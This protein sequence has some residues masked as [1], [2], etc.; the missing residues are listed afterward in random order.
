MQPPRRRSDIW[1]AQYRYVITTLWHQSCSHS[2][3]AF[4]LSTRSLV[5]DLGRYQSD[6]DNGGLAKAPSPQPNQSKANC[7]IYLSVAF[8]Q[9]EQPTLDRLVTILGYS[10]PVRDQPC[11]AESSGFLCRGMAQQQPKEAA[12]ARV[13]VFG[14]SR[15]QGSLLV[16]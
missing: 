11:S 8:L 3:W 12:A 5:I 9:N 15:A 2:A 10:I 1:C 4:D 16:W 6:A 14:S 7:R 13:S